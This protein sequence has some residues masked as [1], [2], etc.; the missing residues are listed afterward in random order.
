MH[1]FE[2]TRL[3]DALSAH[4]NVK[5]VTELH[6][7][8]LAEQWAK[9]RHICHGYKLE[10]ELDGSPV[11][12][13]F[14]VK[15][16]FPLRIP[17]IYLV[18]W[19]LFGILP[20]VE[21]DGYICYAREDATLLDYENPGGI[22]QEA[23]TRAIQ[24]VRDGIS[25]ANH[26]DFMDEFGAYWERFGSTKYKSLVAP[27]DHVKKIHLYDGKAGQKYLADDEQSLKKFKHLPKLSF[28]KHNSAVFVPL[29]PGTLITPPH[30]SNFWG[31]D[32]IRKI[33]FE[34]L[35]PGQDTELLSLL[36]NTHHE[37]V[38]LLSIPK[39]DDGETLI[40][41]RFE[42]VQLEH[43]LKEG[44]KAKA[45]PL[46]IERRDKEYLMPRGG[47]NLALREKCVLLL[48]CGSLGGFI[49]NELTRAGISRL[50]VLDED[51]LNHENI[52]RHVLGIKHVGKAKA[53]AIKNDVEG[54]LPYVE[55]EAIPSSLEDALGTKIKVGDFDL[56]V[57]AL[58]N[59]TVELFLNKYIH[60]TDS[61]PVIYTWLE[62][63]G[64]GGHAVLTNLD[65]G[66]KR[67]L[68][69]LYENTDDEKDKR[70]RISFAAPG[71]N[72]NKNIDGCRNVFTPFGSLDAV[73]TAE[74]A[75]RLAIATLTGDIKAN[76][77]RSWK[78][79]AAEFLKNGKVLSE[80]FALPG[81]VL[82]AADYHS[83]TCSVCHEATI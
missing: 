30:P 44:G 58:A 14:G 10:I 38:I 36:S 9:A 60:G 51:T 71:Q 29:A 79:D 54:R 3:A 6:P 16:S 28:K 7:Q 34:N 81:H 52:Y 40:G 2:L 46:V 11:Q 48:G 24:V 31:L 5:T 35:A 25:G 12:L 57:S 76:L 19:D 32:E 74:L 43:P 21:P 53:E 66:Q 62:P 68:N 69:C 63:Y 22:A 23:L 49:A 77:I 39:R 37:E 20:H 78:G 13:Y 82:E 56:I 83:E 61:P 33:V 64:I 67:C 55:V 26:A 45:V 75:S 72:F 73:R 17:Y 41:I 80:R 47:S 15:K 42:G 59:I 18:K 4:P 8:V 50:T 65:D 70:C 1:K 27:C